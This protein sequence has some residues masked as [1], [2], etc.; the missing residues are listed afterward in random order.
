MGYKIYIVSVCFKDLLH[1]TIKFTFSFSFTF[2]VRTHRY[3]LHW[4]LALVRNANPCFTDMS[5]PT[6]KLPVQEGRDHLWSK[7]KEAFLYVYKHYLEEAD[8]FLKADDDT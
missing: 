4:F 2:S 6:V 8:W 1:C 5:L 3:L 7:T